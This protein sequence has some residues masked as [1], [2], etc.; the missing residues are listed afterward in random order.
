MACQYEILAITEV[1]RLGSGWKTFPIDHSR[2]WW[3]CLRKIDL[4]HWFFYQRISW[5]QFKSQYILPCRAFSSQGESVRQ[6]SQWE[7]L[8]RVLRLLTPCPLHHFRKCFCIKLA[9]KCKVSSP[10]CFM[11]FHPLTN[12]FTN[13]PFLSV[14]HP[15]LQLLI[16][17]FL[18]RRR[19]SDTAYVFSFVAWRIGFGKWE[20]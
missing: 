20:S 19:P 10:P 14:T 5:M 15:P 18:S 8:R 11:H 7:I 16:G 17:G 9:F 6:T 3:T 2:V 4:T 1:G 13:S 12:F